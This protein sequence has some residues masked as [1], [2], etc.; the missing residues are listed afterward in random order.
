M[1]TPLDI[2]NKEFSKG[3]RGYKEVEVDSFL[4]EVIRDYERLI[5]E[6][7]ELKE[8][9]EIIQKKLEHYDNIED[10]LKNTLVVAQKTAEEVNINAKNKS[11]QII[12]SAEH[13]AKK[14]IE[15]AQYEV[16][17]IQKEYEN[18]KKEMLVFKMRF[19]TLLKSQLETSE[20]FFEEI[21]DI[22]E[23]E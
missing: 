18:I 23:D 5:K 19:N 16:V 11:Q 6:N 21:G 1:I 17:E 9:N 15:K 20:K 22:D 12:E 14:I 3:L 10:T 4:D 2:Q 13:E 8:K 7:E